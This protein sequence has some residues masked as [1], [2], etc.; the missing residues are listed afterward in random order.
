MKVKKPWKRSGFQL[1][2]STEAGKISGGPFYNYYILIF[3][4]E[5]CTVLVDKSAVMSDGPT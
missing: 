4:V 5:L 3:S 1:F 2:C